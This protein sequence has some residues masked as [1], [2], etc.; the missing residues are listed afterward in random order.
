MCS[1]IMWFSDCAFPKPRGDR[2]IVGNAQLWP[3]PAPVAPRLPLED[4]YLALLAD[5]LEILSISAADV[6]SALL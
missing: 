6:S 2:Q 5:T 1:L 3:T 4:A